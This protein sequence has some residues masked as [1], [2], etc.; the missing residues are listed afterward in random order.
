VLSRGQGEGGYVGMR[1]WEDIGNQDVATG[2][3]VGGGRRLMELASL[4]S[5]RGL[6]GARASALSREPGQGRPVRCNFLRGGSCRPE[7]G[8][9][10]LKI[11]SKGHDFPSGEREEARKVTKSA[12]PRE[13]ENEA[14]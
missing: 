6:R 4:F 2:S 12:L 11:S 9:P 10:S 14:Y 1:K 13:G 7:G 3:R 5:E 8:D